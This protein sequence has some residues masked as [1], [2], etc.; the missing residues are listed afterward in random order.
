[1]RNI[2]RLTQPETRKGIHEKKRWKFMS[3]FGENL[4]YYRKRDDMTQE[5]LAEQLEVSR[6]T[7]S[8]W[9]A[10]AS[11][12]EMEKLLQL[13]DLFDCDLDTLLRKNASESEIED[14]LLHRE[15]MKEFRTW[16]TGGIALL[17]FSF[18]F[19]EILE[20]FGR[21]NDALK[22]TLFMILAIV[23]ILIL[24]VQGLKDSNYRKKHPVI[25]NFY[26]PGERE[27]FD[28]HFPT[29]IATGVGLILIGLLF[30]M[31][32]DTLPLPDS[33]NEDFYYGI[34]LLFVTAAV[35][36]LVYT[37]M[38]KQEYDID[39]YNKNNSPQANAQN[40]PVTVWCGCIMLL[41][42]IVFLIAGLVF[43]LWEICWIAYPIGGILCGMVTLILNRQK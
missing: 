12:A 34:F 26:T 4:Q 2:I 14:N 13:C 36:V 15:H 31:N 40:S 5:Q 25:Q 23:A 43:H 42:T 32:G 22:N 19:Y 29:K 20:G 35:S 16:I 9:E 17:V 11:Y 1:M 33:M 7:V 41:A 27:E 21:I 39:A 24:I 6:Q 3:L 8:K 28:N 18:S 37:G 30:G 38:H 10:G